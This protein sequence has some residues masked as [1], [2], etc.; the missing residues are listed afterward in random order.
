MSGV[1]TSSQF[2]ASL[3][4]FDTWFLLLRLSILRLE[5]SCGVRLRKFFDES[6][7]TALR[8]VLRLQDQV[9]G[10]ARMCVGSCAGTSS[11]SRSRTSTTG[12]C[13]CLCEPRPSTFYLR[14]SRGPLQHLETHRE[15]SR[16][17]ID[18]HARPRRRARAEPAFRGGSRGGRALALLPSA[19]RSTVRWSSAA[20]VSASSFSA[21]SHF[22]LR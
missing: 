18:R 21:S 7:A 16:P 3:A 19:S 22:S 9:I 4:F 13:R 17:R 15:P 8:W 20:D 10:V 5:F 12:R 2:I 1:H 6:Q 14:L 11:A